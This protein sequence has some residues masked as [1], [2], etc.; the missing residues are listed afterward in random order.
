MRLMAGEADLEL[1][2]PIDLAS[3]EHRAIEE[4]GRVTLLDDLKADALQR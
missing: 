4:K 2:R 1:G 3:N